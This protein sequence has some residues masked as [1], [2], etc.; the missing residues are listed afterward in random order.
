MFSTGTRTYREIVA[1]LKV[2][3]Y[4]LEQS[5]LVG[6]VVKHR[7]CEGDLTRDLCNSWI[8]SKT[9]YKTV[10]PMNFIGET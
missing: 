5:K 1:A 7:E 6:R 4:I 10:R 3:Q 9:V 8:Y 2:Q